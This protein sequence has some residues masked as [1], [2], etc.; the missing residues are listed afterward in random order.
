MKK[1]L[2]IRFG[3]RST[4]IVISIDNYV[5]RTGR[6]RYRLKAFE[7]R[8]QRR[9]VGRKGDEVIGRCRVGGLL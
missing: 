2:Q 4:R 3:F 6:E 8:V 7:N 5:L 1:L 9:I